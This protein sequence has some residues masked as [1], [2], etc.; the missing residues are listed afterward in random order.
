M[1]LTLYEGLDLALKMI[2]IVIA[3]IGLYLLIE[4]SNGNHNNK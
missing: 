4:Q 2:D 1:E 3:V